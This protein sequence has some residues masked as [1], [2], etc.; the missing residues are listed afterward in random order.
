MMLDR[1]PDSEYLVVSSLR[2]TEAHIRE[3]IRAVMD[4]EDQGGDQPLFPRAQV[5]RALRWMMVAFNS[6]LYD[7]APDDERKPAYFAS[8]AAAVSIVGTLGYSLSSWLV[9]HIHVVQPVV[10]GDLSNLRLMFLLSASLLVVPNLLLFFVTEPSQTKQKN[11]WSLVWRSRP[12]MFVYSSYVFS[13]SSDE[14]KRATAARTMGRSR[15]AMAVDRL[16]EALEDPSYKVR[17]E[18]A[19][20]LGETLHRDAVEPLVRQLDDEESDIR[21]EAAEALGRLAAPEAATPLLRA[22]DAPDLRIR[23]SAV[24][25]LIGVGGEEIRE[26]LYEKFCEPFDRELFPSL[27]EALS[28]YRDLRIVL[29]A[30]DAIG[31]FRSPVIKLQMLD[32]VCRTLGADRAFYQIISMPDLPRSEELGKLL[33][34]ARRHVRPDR[35]DPGEGR[36][37]VIQ[38][39]DEVIQCFEEERPEGLLVAARKAAA[40]VAGSSAGSAAA[41]VCRDALDRFSQLELTADDQ[42]PHTLADRARE[43]FPVICLQQQLLYLSSE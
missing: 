20:G 32:C 17:S 39:L 23:I 13:R 35:R 25:A 12:L 4:T 33:R 3:G 31:N 18:A 29:P 37:E 16:A 22:L 5:G 8:W 9:K 36:E 19:K 42:E 34:K 28:H 30:L 14:A 24:R 27:T 21:L 43:V 40:L 38:A 41:V 1:L 6:L 15:S 2:R 10:G 7:I 11:I 26:K